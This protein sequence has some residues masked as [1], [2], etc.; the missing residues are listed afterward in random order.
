[1][2]PPKQK[3]E[4]AQ[5]ADLEAWVKMGAPDP[6]TD[7]AVIS[8][9]EQRLAEAKKHWAFQPIREPAVP[10]LAD[11]TVQSPIDAFIVS[12]LA[13]KGLTPSPPA[14]KRTLIRRAYVDLIGLPP[15]PEDV[16]AF[17]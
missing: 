5:I 6:R 1:Q 14:D 12:K 15:L 10:A 16:A 7:S 2:M 17:I 11:K 8:P 13:E 4:T 3:L 9:I